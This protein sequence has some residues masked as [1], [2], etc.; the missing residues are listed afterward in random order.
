[1]DRITELPG[2]DGTRDADELRMDAADMLDE[3]ETD[4]EAGENEIDLT[5]LEAGI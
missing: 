4:D 3:M 2:E 5:G 1:M